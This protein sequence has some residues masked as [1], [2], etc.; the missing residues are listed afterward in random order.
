MSHYD[1]FSTTP[2]PFGFTDTRGE[3]ENHYDSVHTFTALAQAVNDVDVSGPNLPPPPQGGHLNPYSTLYT[4]ANPEEVLNALTTYFASERI[5]FVREDAFTV[6]CYPCVGQTQ[7]PIEICTFTNNPMDRSKGAYAFEFRNQ[8]LDSVSFFN[9]F[10]TAKDLLVSKSLINSGD[11]R[12]PEETAS[13][14]GV[15]GDDDYLP[16]LSLAAFDMSLLDESELGATMEDSIED[17][18]ASFQ[19]LVNITNQEDTSI[20]TQAV[21]GIVDIMGK[22]P[23]S[24]G[25]ALDSGAFDVLTL[26]ICEAAQHM[27]EASLALDAAS[28]IRDMCHH[29]VSG[30]A[31]AC[32]VSSDARMATIRSGALHALLL[33]V[34]SLADSYA[35]HCRELVRE[36]LRAYIHIVS[37]LD[38]SLMA[39]LLEKPLT[40][41]SSCGSCLSEMI[42]ALENHLS[43]DCTSD[44]YLQERV[45]TIKRQLVRFVN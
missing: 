26:C 42:G 22:S 31:N 25:A 7:I 4:D 32:E 43:T 44:V 13:K 28:P 35:V 39:Q 38:E 23:R 15:I 17:L 40:D 20:K 10:R 1:Q 9:M 14:D 3:A 30:I 8:S 37:E 6:R 21:R 36:T 16:T 27:S 29:A 2:E 18:V 33:F 5:D 45:D 24:I 11:A 41:S 19:M 34:S 12:K